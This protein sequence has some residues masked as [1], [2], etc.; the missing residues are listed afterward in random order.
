M[1]LEAVLWALV[2]TDIRKFTT[3]TLIGQKPTIY[4]A[5]YSVE[6]LSILSF[7]LS[8]FY[9]SRISHFLSVYWSNFSHVLPISWGGCYASKL[10]ESV[11]YSLT[12]TC[13]I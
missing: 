13:D 7:V 11:V 10:I 5:G 12:I 3:S 4:H 1:N 9:K 6:N 2:V 8:L